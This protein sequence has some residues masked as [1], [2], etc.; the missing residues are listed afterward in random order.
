MK[1]ARENAGARKKAP[2]ASAILM[3]VAQLAGIRRQDRPYFCAELRHVLNR[4]WN[5][6]GIAE[7][8]R[9]EKC[10]ESLR[11]VLK[12]IRATHTAIQA[13]EDRVQDW[14]GWN[15]EAASV[16][17]MRFDKTGVPAREARDAKGLANCWPLIIKGI[18]EVIAYSVGDNPYALSGG[19]RGRPRGPADWLF[20]GLVFDLHALVLELD[21]D[22][23]A[24][25]KQNV[26]YGTMFEALE[27]LA[28][29]LPKG[30]LRVGTAQ[31]VANVVKRSRMGAQL[32]V[33]I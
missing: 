24:S 16:F 18:M 1:G 32:R 10:Q 11:K 3:G 12:N 28:P 15:L 13:L 30:F 2:K 22:L 8:A 9:K 31:T 27:R 19:K 33:P 7:E 5:N 4:L 17:S 26:G 6:W 14:V 29:L 23:K 21:G 25:C 20:Q